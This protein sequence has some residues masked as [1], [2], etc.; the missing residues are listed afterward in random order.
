MEKIIIRNWINNLLAPAMKENGCPSE[1]RTEEDVLSN[2]YYLSKE[3]GRGSR[4]IPLQYKRMIEKLIFGLF[5]TSF[6]YDDK[7]DVYFEQI[8]DATVCC[9]NVYL[10]SF[11][12]DGTKKVLGHGFHCL[13]L[14]EVMPGVFL[15]DAERA[16]KW[17]STVIGGAKSRALYDAGIGLEFYGDVFTPEENLDEN[18][19]PKEEKTKKEKSSDKS[20]EKTYSDSGMPIPKPKRVV[21]EAITADSKQVQADKDKVA[22]IGNDLFKDTM[23]IENAKSV[24]ADCGNY[25]GMTLGEIYETA[26]KNLVFLLRN[27]KDKK[28]QLAAETI[29]S[30]DP[31]LKEKYIS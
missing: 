28:V 30:A 4:Y 14:E 26:P 12:E 17:K 20:L 25:I 9:A 19:L 7:K 13:S 23:T 22:E 24:S 2:L 3:D 10:V 6:E 11:A 1:I 18:D 5:S 31:E 27:S 15:T 29:V 8:G 21:K 16:S